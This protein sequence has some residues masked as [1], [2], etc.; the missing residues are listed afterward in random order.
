MN[1]RD[2]AFGSTADHLGPTNSRLELEVE[3]KYFGRKRTQKSL[4]HCAP[5]LW[6]VAG[7][8]LGWSRKGMVTEH[9]PLGNPRTSRTAPE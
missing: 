9:L 6:A 2:V 3:R 4:P 5:R 7:P 8:R 1:D